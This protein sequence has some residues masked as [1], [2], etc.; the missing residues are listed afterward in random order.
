MNQAYQP[1]LVLIPSPP[2]NGNPCPTHESQHGESLQQLS[3]THCAISSQQRRKRFP[4]HPF[5]SGWWRQVTCVPVYAVMEVGVDPDVCA[6]LAKAHHIS[7][8]TR[9]PPAAHLH[10]MMPM[11]K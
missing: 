8:S 2:S 11:M 5:R 6:A 7:A 1:S 3:P 10:S 9:S 4:K